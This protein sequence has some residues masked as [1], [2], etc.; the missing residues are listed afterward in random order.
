MQKTQKLVTNK[1]E[2][3]RRWAAS[4]KKVRPP[5]HVLRRLFAAP[6]VFIYLLCFIYFC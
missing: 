2:A 5:E 1:M 4:K 3:V 6:Q